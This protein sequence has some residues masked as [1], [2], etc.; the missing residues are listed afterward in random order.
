MAVCLNRRVPVALC[1]Q[2]DLGA[3]ITFSLSPL[4]LLSFAVGQYLLRQTFRKSSLSLITDVKGLPHG[5]G[6]IAD[7]FETL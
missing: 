3:N 2:T 4:T 1:V 5:A 6:A 7:V